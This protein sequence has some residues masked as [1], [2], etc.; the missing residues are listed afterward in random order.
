MDLR[1]IQVGHNLLSQLNTRLVSLRCSIHREGKAT[2]RSA[3][4]RPSAFD[5]KGVGACLPAHQQGKPD[6]RNMRGI[7]F[8]TSQ[9]LK[10]CLVA[11]T[12][13]NGSFSGKRPLFPFMRRESIRSGGGV[14][15]EIV[16]CSVFVISVKCYVA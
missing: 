15:E 13:V 4:S 12:D 9:V 3:W 7:L 16:D 5:G 8:D 11:V 2:Q 1:F 6:E 14:E 10:H